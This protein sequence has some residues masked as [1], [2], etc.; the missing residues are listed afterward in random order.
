MVAEWTNAVR[1]VGIRLVV[2]SG[3]RSNVTLFFQ[4]KVIL[5]Q[6]FEYWQ[7]SHAQSFAQALV[8]ASGARRVVKSQRSA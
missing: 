4:G 3:H 2:R 6:E 7:E 1:G 8:V 5:Y